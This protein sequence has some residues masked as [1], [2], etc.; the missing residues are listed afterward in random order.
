LNGTLI[1]DKLS[2]HT[3]HPLRLPKVSTSVFLAPYDP[4]A[5]CDYVQKIL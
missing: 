1:R 2:N 5:Y 4:Y 3:D